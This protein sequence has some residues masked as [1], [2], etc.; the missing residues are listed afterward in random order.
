[1]RTRDIAM[2]LLLAMGAMLGLLAVFHTPA[3]EGTIPIAHAA[4]PQM[5]QRAP[6]ET[7]CV[8]PSG[9]I[10]PGCDQAFTQIQAAV[11]AA[12]GGELIKVAAGVYDDL[13]TRNALTHWRGCG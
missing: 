10:P 5:S 11:D 12:S 2:S 9:A 13:H 7:F 4:P 3:S 8:S 1:M 6:E